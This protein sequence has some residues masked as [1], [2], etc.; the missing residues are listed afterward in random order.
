MDKR[1]PDYDYSMRRGAARGGSVLAG[2]IIGGI[3][4]AGTMLLLAPQSGRETR[5]QLQQGAMDLRDRATDTVNAT[6]S[7]VRSRAQDMMDNV[8]GKASDLTNQGRD[9]AIDQLDKVASTAQSGKQ[10]LK[11]SKS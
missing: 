6:A 10:A 1:N 7:Q 8:R 2:L 3:L 9:I 11:N 4:G 5:E